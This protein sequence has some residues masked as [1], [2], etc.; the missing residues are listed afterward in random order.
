MTI[1]TASTDHPKPATVLIIDNFLPTRMTVSV[2]FG[3]AGYKVLEC[4]T[5]YLGLDIA[6]K[7]LPD[8][9]LIDTV[10]PGLD[11]F[12]V[13]RRLKSNVLTQLIPVVI[14]ATFGTYQDRMK[15]IEVDS[16]Y[17]FTKPFDHQE[18]LARA[19]LLIGQKPQRKN[20]FKRTQQVLFS[21]AQAIESRDP[22]TGEHCKRLASL[23]EKFSRFLALSKRDM[24][25]LVWGAYLH[26]I[27]KVV[28]PDS[29]LL[30]PQQLSE[31]EFQAMRQHTVLGEKICQPLTEILGPGVLQIIR[32]H[33]E[34]WNGTGYPDQL[35]EDDIPFLAQVF[36]LL[37]IYDALVSIRPY[38]TALSPVETLSIMK[39]ETDKGWYNPRLMT[40]FV[41]FVENDLSQSVTVT[42]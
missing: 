30:K 11:G 13:C 37:D 41:D 1:T 34:R 32:H 3:M 10:L 6:Q 8:I 15:A 23:G 9:I 36:Q 26:D 18:V 24:R 33:H 4:D 5:G 2:A 31:Q 16:D 19:E 21:I 40:R 14:T 35:A 20:C 39:E 42:A 38:K 7:L 27:G 25:D 12:E 29:I 28:I 17:F 22:N